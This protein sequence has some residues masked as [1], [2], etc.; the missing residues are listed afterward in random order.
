MRKVHGQLNAR[1]IQEFKELYTI[2]PAHGHVGGRLRE[3]IL[4][5]NGIL[6]GDVEYTRHH[7]QYPRSLGP[8]FSKNC[9]G[10]KILRPESR[11]IAPQSA[12]PD[13]ATPCREA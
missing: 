9:R 11:E 13:D 5:L 3:A 8:K 2:I 10:H 1:S 7:P 12:F 4:V 6:P